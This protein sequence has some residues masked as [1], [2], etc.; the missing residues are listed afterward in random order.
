[1]PARKGETGPQKTFSNGKGAG[2]IRNSG[3]R[4]AGGTDGTEREARC[5]IGGGS[6]RGS[7]V[8]VSR[9]S[10]PRGGGQGDHRGGRRKRVL[11]Q[12]RVPGDS[13]RDSGKG[14]RRRLRRGDHTGR[15]RARPD[16]P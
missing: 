15:L 2:R 13:R 12:A 4:R 7:R 11:L 10:V 9:A 3:Y 14:K 5:R 8:V 1:M 6:L 16:A